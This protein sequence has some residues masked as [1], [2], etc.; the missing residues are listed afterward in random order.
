MCYSFSSQLTMSSISP[1]H[2]LL[3]LND[4]CPTC[5]RP[6]VIQVTLRLPSQRPIP[7]AIPQRDLTVYPQ[8]NPT[9]LYPLIEIAQ[10]LG[11][12]CIGYVS[13]SQRCTYAANTNLLYKE[14]CSLHQ[15]QGEKI[16]N[17][18]LKRKKSGPMVVSELTW[19]HETIECG[20]TKE[21]PSQKAPK[22]EAET[23]SPSTRLP[24]QASPVVST[25]PPPSSTTV[26]SVH[27]ER[28]STQR[29]ND[30]PRAAY[31][32]LDGIQD[33]ALRK[34]SGSA[35]D[36][37]GL[38]EGVENKEGAEEGNQPRTRKRQRRNECNFAGATTIVV[39][40][41]HVFPTEE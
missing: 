30:V 23:L 1:S 10:Q 39:L 22:P 34:K 31:P 12:R 36:L 18:P 26:S 7:M 35:A 37:E 9:T 11:P 5:F 27:V 6:F 2:G 8:G 24:Y 4:L 32:I 15:I 17:L 38:D 21:A 29:A 40:Y 33:H 28:G 25:Q 13:S 19:S 16:N 3:E 41:G 14:F 20:R